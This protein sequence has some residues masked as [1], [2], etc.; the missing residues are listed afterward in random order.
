MLIISHENHFIVT[1]Y[2]LTES[3]YLLL[4]YLIG[5][6]DASFICCSCT[7]YIILIFFSILEPEEIEREIAERRERFRSKE[8][9][10]S[11]ALLIPQVGDKTWGENRTFSKVDMVGEITGFRHKIGTK[12]DRHCMIKYLENVSSSKLNVPKFGDR[13]D[14]LPV[15]APLLDYLE[16]DISN[17]E[18][19]M[20]PKLEDLRS[21]Q[22]HRGLSWKMK[23]EVEV[24]EL[25]CG[26]SSDQEI[27][28]THRWMNEM[29]QI[30]QERFGSKVISMDVEDVQVTYHDCLRMARKVPIENPGSPILTKPSRNSLSKYGK[31]GWRQIP[32]KIMIGNGLTWMAVISLNMRRNTK[33]EYILEPMTVQQGI[34]DLL[35]DLPVSAGLGVRRD[36]RGIEEF[37]SL[38]ADKPVQLING[39]ID[40]AAMAIAAGFKFHAR[41]MTALG[42]QIIGT[43]MNKTVSTGDDMWGLKWDDIPD[44]LQIYGIGDIKFGFI[45]YIVLAG[46]LLRDLFPDPDIVCWYMKCEQEEAVKW[47]LDWLVLSLE[48]VEFHADAESRAVTR[49]ELLYSLRF[50]DAKDKLCSSPPKYIVLWTRLIGSWSSI[51]HGGC[52]FLIQPREWFLVQIRTLARANIQWMDD[53]ILRVPNEADLE[54]AR[55]GMT[56]EQIGFQSWT[57]PVSGSWGFARPSSI[58]VPL[59]DLDPSTALSKDIGRACTQIRRF[60][61]WTILEWGRMNPFKMKSFFARMIRNAGFRIFYKSL[62]DAL[63]LMFLRI[64]CESAPLVN[65]LE[66]ELNNGV[67]KVYQEEKKAL[68]KV[69]IE[70][71]VRRERVSYMEEVKLN[72]KLK[73]RSRWRE[74]IPELPVWK[75]RGG[76]TGKK[77]PRSQSRSRARDV[78]PKKMRLM[79]KARKSSVL[80]PVQPAPLGVRNV[81]GD[82]TEDNPGNKEKVGERSEGPGAANSGAEKPVRAGS[83]LDGYVTET[84]EVGEAGTCDD[85]IEEELPDT[86]SRAL[87]TTR[88]RRSRSRSVNR[89]LA[90]TRILTH[91]ELMEDLQRVIEDDEPVGLNGEEIVFEI[92]PEVEQYNFEF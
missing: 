72:W 12:R 36:V 55:F 44:A 34:L 92:P 47:F 8:F 83:V 79:G 10:R 63:R 9:D 1:I 26:V 61:R 76:A 21:F 4:D 70:V 28:D 58:T 15:G 18:G 17:S 89:R 68:E 77:R 46:I 30:D 40:L 90:P 59:I 49:E 60:Q 14:F 13:R 66:K 19:W 20:F 84:D 32:G 86:S 50:R 62:Y 2:Y 87:L 71:A 42:V 16:Q 33:N 48:G 5:I 43:I 51:T 24:R 75:R 37:Y 41:N 11:Q 73:E 27:R 22:A 35:R 88:R 85:V 64:F 38:I 39:F 7:V 80:V 29:Y 65:R 52:R 53:R 45:V 57:E 91:D 82:C 3:L 56:S 23:D 54:Y 69:E 67:E 74:R 81:S 25:I 31:D 78:K 6:S